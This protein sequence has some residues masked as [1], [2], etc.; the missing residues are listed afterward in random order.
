MLRCLIAWLAAFALTTASLPAFADSALPVSLR[1]AGVSQEQWD[2]LQEE[3]RLTASRANVS[4]R[5]LAAVAERLGLALAEGGR[6]VNV[7]DI[8]NQLGSLARR[9]LELETRLTVLARDEDPAISTLIAQAQTAVGAGDLDAADVAL[10][11]ARQARAER[12][13]LR[14][15]QLEAGQLEEA[16]IVAAQAEVALL[17]IDYLG[18]SALFAEAAELAPDGAR[19]KWSYTLAQADALF[20]RADEFFDADAAQRAIE[21]YRDRALPLSPRDDFPE[22]WAATHIQLADAHAR[23]GEDE[24]AAAAYRAA[25]EVFTREAYP[26]VWADTQRELA[27]V[28]PDLNEAAALYREVLAASPRETDPDMWAAAQYGLGET[29]LAL[30]EAGDSDATMEGMR[31]LREVADAFPRDSVWWAG[32]QLAIAGAAR[33]FESPDDLRTL[34]ATA[35]AQVADLDRERQPG[36]WVS[37][38]LF[39]AYMLGSADDEATLHEAAAAFR[40]V[41]E[42][43]GPDTGVYWVAAQMGLADV[44]LTL[45]FERESDEDFANLYAAIAALEAAKQVA[46]RA[47]DPDGWAEIEIRRAT[48][49]GLLGSHRNRALLQD[50][51][52]IYRAAQVEL[53]PREDLPLWGEAALMSGEIALELGDVAAAEAA[54]RSALEHLDREGDRD[55]AWMWGWA[56]E[57]LGDVLMMQGEYGDDAP[58]RA[59]L[60]AYDLAMQVRTRAAAPE[61]WL[62]LMQKRALTYSMIGRRGDLEA[63]AQAVAVRRELQQVLSR[64]ISPEAWA[65]LQYQVALDLR[66][67]VRQEQRAQ[68][69]AAIEAARAAL[70]AASSEQSAERARALIAELEA[71]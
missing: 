31:L 21:V 30:G 25:L 46:P 15:A 60:T 49:L 38:Q 7:A 22:G 2:A 54:F 44:L 41:F 1:A 35:R 66:A 12:N 10:A 23:L 13:A 61:D 36:T 4:E 9:I 70:D 19:E 40:E 57:G 5:A 48:I 62:D 20:A 11:A 52:R 39:L 28:V 65:A 50:A 27:G 53:S 55:S 32:V 17:R 71:L 67:M 8:L 58:L 26:D 64:D 43:I 56:Q 63:L 24:Q 69:P 47:E 6:R 51:L 18:A 14:R 29:L 42:V 59:A 37:A 33:N 16:A 3:V 45:G 34:I 68:L